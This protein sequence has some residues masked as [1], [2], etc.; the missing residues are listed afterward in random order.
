MVAQANYYVKERPQCAEGVSVGE[1]IAS[2]DG[3]PSS[4]EKKIFD[5]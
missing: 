4:F 1:K 2:K 3:E 5:H